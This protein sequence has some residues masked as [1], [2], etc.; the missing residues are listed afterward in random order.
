MRSVDE[1]I[2]SLPDDLADICERLRGIIIATV[3]GATE[4]ISFRIP[5]YHYHGMFCYLNRVKDGIDVGF[6]RGKD[7]TE[8]FPQL[9]RGNRKIVAS[10][11]VRNRADIMRLEL[12]AIVAAAAEWNEEAA[13]MKKSFLTASTKRKIQATSS[14]KKSARGRR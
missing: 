5:F 2:S 6:L 1:Y 8:I 11:T 9:Q 7:L 3:P 14:G 12:P 10:V 13:R 4:K